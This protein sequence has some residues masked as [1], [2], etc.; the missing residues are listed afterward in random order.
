MESNNCPVL[1]W[2]PILILPVL[3]VG[4]Q[5]G[6]KSTSE[7]QP[8]VSTAP[9][10]MTTA[11]AELKPTK[12]NKAHGTVTFTQLPNG[13]RVVAEIH[14]L[15]KNSVHG[16]HIHEK[17]DCSAHD[18]SSAGGH[19]NPTSK[20]HGSPEDAEHHVGDFGNVTADKKG[21]VHF[22]Q[23]FVG[24]SINGATSP[25]IGKAVILHAKAD[26]LRSQPSGNAGARAACGVIH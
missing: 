3:L 24:L 17:G 21:E 19:Y 4:C 6:S 2:A 23:D 15:K 16:F 8:A 26:D 14:G 18:A 25:I 10:P 7:A 12:G 9:A 22:Q 5:S 13:V 11:V 20:P 1:K